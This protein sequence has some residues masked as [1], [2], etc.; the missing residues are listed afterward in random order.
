MIV[1][2]YTK[3]VSVEC[4]FLYKYKKILKIK[5]D[6][7]LNNYVRRA[8]FLHKESSQE[9]EDELKVMIS[10][11]ESA[12]QAV[13]GT[14]EKNMIKYDEISNMYHCDI[15]N[16]S[17]KGNI[18]KI[19]DRKLLTNAKIKAHQVVECK[20]RNNCPNILHQKYCKFYHYPHDLWELV[21]ECKISVEFYK[22]TIKYTRNF[23][24]TSWIHSFKCRP[25][26]RNID[27]ENIELSIRELELMGI[28]QREINSYKAQV[29]HDILVLRKI[30]S[31]NH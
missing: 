12:L 7:T 15:D 27:P 28:K 11:L 26:M 4:I 30:E 20:M 25:Y 19:Y 9:A 6:V 1:P 29:M 16:I 18:G 22:E 5:M 14:T 10:F 24:N 21:G 2:F 13:K 23:V 8:Q 17:L 3:T 31:L